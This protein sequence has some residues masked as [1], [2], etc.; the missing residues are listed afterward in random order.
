MDDLTRNEERNE[1]EQNSYAEDAL[2]KN[3]QNQTSE[4]V[5]KAPGDE[6]A[7]SSV[8][9]TMDDTTGKLTCPRCGKTFDAKE[10]H[11]PYCGLKN[12]L[13]ICE[14]CGETIA[15]NAKRCPKCG[16]KNKKPKTW[17]WIA[18]A[19]VALAII[20]ISPSNGG[21]NETKVAAEQSSAEEPG[22]SVE[23]SSTQEQENSTKA[24]TSTATAADEMDIVGK[25]TATQL[26][27]LSDEDIVDLDDMGLSVEINF[28]TDHTGTVI[29]SKG[30]TT[31]F[32]WNYVL[33]TDKGDEVYAV[34]EL[35]IYVIRDKTNEF[36]G[37]FLLV[38]DDKVM[39]FEPSNTG[40]STQKTSDAAKMQ[41]D[42]STMTSGQRNALKS[43][44]SYLRSSA[45]SYT[46]LIEQ[47][48][49]EGFS[50]EDATYA[51]DHCGADWKEQA[52]KSAESYLKYSSFSKSG[53]IDQL[54]FE[55]FTH[56][57]AV[58]GVEQAY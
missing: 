22:T 3:E 17:V 56:E 1:K 46:G 14:I 40:S 10:K 33:T 49:Y 4:N 18:V 43:A 26:A 50:N 8:S 53:L 55:G 21:K 39:V 27:D 28:N 32:K 45:F 48:E 44:E 5:E 36:E 19:V 13:K 34:G 54:E 31:E 51:A 52:V 41:S 2:R 9:S 35:E 15:K 42:S 23:K 20:F 25:W 58:Y 12:D 47:L 37:K 24:S 6:N 30:K 38:N 16:T 11:C 57:Q 7:D 29:T